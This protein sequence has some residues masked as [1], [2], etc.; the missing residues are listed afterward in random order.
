MPTFL[1][2]MT[3]TSDGGWA[4]GTAGGTAGDGGGSC[5][6]TGVL[7]FGKNAFDLFAFIVDPRQ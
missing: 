7:F 2:G 4:S 3:L 6:N 5:G 1:F